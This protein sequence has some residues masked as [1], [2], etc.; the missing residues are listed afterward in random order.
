[1]IVYALEECVGAADSFEQRD[2][3]RK[4]VGEAFDAWCKQSE[5]LKRP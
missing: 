2:D 1:M 5:E 4:I 3:G